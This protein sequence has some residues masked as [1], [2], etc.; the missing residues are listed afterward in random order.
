MFLSTG[1]NYTP[2][3]SMS[4]G[5]A[6]YRQRFAFPLLSREEQGII[7]YRVCEDDLYL[8]HCKRFQLKIITKRY[9]FSF[10]RDLSFNEITMIPRRVFFDVKSL[11]IL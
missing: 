6:V 7:T 2:G 11:K 9:T 10:P 8:I 1:E 4:K 3:Q 5:V